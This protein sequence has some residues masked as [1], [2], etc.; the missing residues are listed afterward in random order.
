MYKIRST[1]AADVAHLPAIERSAAQAFLAI[2]DLAWIATDSVQTEAQHHALIAGGT[3][4][5]AVDVDDAPVGFLTAEMTDGSLHICEVS[6][7]RDFQGKG[8]GKALMAAARHWA[9]RKAIAQ[10]TLITFRDVPW[11]EPFYKKLGFTTVAERDLSPELLR[12]LDDDANTGLP[13]AK[14]CAMVRAVA[15]I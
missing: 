2:P 8:L 15:E 3:A 6:V 12:R 9:A 14:R 4:W 7:R 10:L 11:N 5:V 1:R 13:R